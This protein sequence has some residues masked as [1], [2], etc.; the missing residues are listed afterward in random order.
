VE[1]ETTYDGT[2]AA[3]RVEGDQR[4]FDGLADMGLAL[5]RALNEPVEALWKMQN[6]YA[7]CTRP[8]LDVAPSN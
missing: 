8:G 6:G 1:R 7:L 3:L 4:Q 2:R 5:A